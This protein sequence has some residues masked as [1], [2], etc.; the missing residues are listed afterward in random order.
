MRLNFRK[1]LPIIMKLLFVQPSSK[2]IQKIVSL[3]KEKLENITVEVWEATKRPVTCAEIRNAKADLLVNFNLSGF[4][5]R[6]LTD[7]ISYNLLDC[8][9]IHILLKAGLPNEKYL[10]KQLSISMFFYCAS[11]DYCSYLRDRYADI[12]YLRVIEGWKEEEDRAEENAEILYGVI[13]E[14]V[15]NCRMDL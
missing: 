6:T 15:K 11:F 8:K 10:A 13:R 12:P 2:Q 14:V 9:Q 5:Q 1:G 3:V 7:G 4:E